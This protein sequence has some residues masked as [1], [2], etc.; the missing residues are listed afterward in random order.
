M[1]ISTGTIKTR[2]IEELKKISE[3]VK[4]NLYRIKIS[5]GFIYLVINL[6]LFNMFELISK[7]KIF[8]SCHGAFTHVALIMACIYL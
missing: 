5:R 3:L 6:D 7:S 2:I 1:I 8:I 4:D